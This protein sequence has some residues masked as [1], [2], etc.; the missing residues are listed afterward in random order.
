MLAPLTPPTV[1]PAPDRQETAADGGMVRAAWRFVTSRVGTAGL[2]GPAI[3]ALSVLSTA[4]GVVVDLMGEPA[5]GAGT[6]VAVVF[7]A[8][9]G[10]AVVRSGSLATTAVLPPL[11]FAAAATALARLGGQNSGLR[12]VVLDVGTTLAL[13]APLVFGAT[14]AGLLVVLVRVGRRI[15]RRRS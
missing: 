6:G 7:C 11:L 14:A 1:T 15:V 3:V 9:A 8:V 10:P 4:V 13:S 12:E 2:T 5:L